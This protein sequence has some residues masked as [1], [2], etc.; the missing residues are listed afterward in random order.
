MLD[1][2]YRSQPHSYGRNRGIQKAKIRDG[3][4][5]SRAVPG[6]QTVGVHGPTVFIWTRVT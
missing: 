4:A 3:W 1:G 6:R 2:I 5:T